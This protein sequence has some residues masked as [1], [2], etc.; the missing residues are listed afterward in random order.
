[1]N[2]KNCILYFGILSLLFFTACSSKPIADTPIEEAPSLVDIAS[3]EDAAKDEVALDTEALAVDSTTNKTIENPT[4]DYFYDELEFAIED[5]N[6]EIAK[7]KTEI[8]LL[9]EQLNALNA[10]SDVWS[11]PL[12][13][14]S[15]KVVMSTGT[16]LFGNIVYQDESVVHIETFIGTLSV[17][18]QDIIRVIDNQI[19]TAQADN[20]VLAEVN[21]IQSAM[22]DDSSNNSY[23]N[24]AKIILLGDFAE[25][26]DDNY[27]TMLTGQVKNIGNK[28]ADFVKLNFTI[29]KDKNLSNN[30]ASYTVFVDG[31][32]M[33]FD[34]DLTSTSSIPPSGVGNFTLVIPSDFGPFTSYTYT[35]DWEQY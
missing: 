16:S 10:V 9:K 22:N 20:T 6:T 11:E 27:N 2:I 12:S 14:Y 29:Y 21:A 15:K 34:N 7:L 8:S 25:S 35:I 28:R 19:I 26:K 1:M 32:T 13:L 33:Q 31:T 24:S 23:A 3:I 5:H 4:P 30:S 17:P 18:R